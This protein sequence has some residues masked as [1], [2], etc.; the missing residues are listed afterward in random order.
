[1][2]AG[3]KATRPVG[4]RGSHSSLPVSVWVKH[5]GQQ[6]PCGPAVTHILTDTDSTRRWVP[7]LNVGIDPLILC[8]GNSVRENS[9]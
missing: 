2:T 9:S 1:M 8:T 3:V 7:D 5:T 4:G 6:D